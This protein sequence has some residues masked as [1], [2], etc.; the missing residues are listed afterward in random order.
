MN[1]ANIQNYLHRY[2]TGRLYEIP[3]IYLFDWESDFISVTRAGYIHE[4]EIKI[5]KSDFNNDAK[6]KAHKHEV[7]IHGCRPLKKY[8][9]ICVDDYADRG[10]EIPSYIS[11]KLTGDNK[12]AGKRPN[13]FWYVCPV[14]LIKEVPEYA[15]LIFCNPHLEI[16]K[17]A[18]LLHK[19]KISTEMKGKILSSFYYR[20]W[21][22]RLSSKAVGAINE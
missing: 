5:S 4:Y 16:I 17:P 9:K 22:L 21:K 10:W 20:Y 3:N 18:P 6:S 7:L 12:I 2:F 15:G 13:Y 14:D 1:E 11:N 8:E 19:E